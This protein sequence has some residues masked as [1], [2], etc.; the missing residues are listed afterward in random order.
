MFLT[1]LHQLQTMH[2]AKDEWKIVMNNEY[3]IMRKVKNA[4]T[5]K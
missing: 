5:L 3:V 4:S 2:I 1:S